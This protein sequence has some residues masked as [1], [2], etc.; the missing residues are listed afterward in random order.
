MSRYLRNLIIASVALH[1]VALVAAIIYFE[2]FYTPEEPPETGPETASSSSS[3]SSSSSANSNE[4]ASSSQSKPLSEDEIAQFIE[5]KKNEIKNS[6]AEEKF[7]KLEH[8]FKILNPE[9]KDS[10]DMQKLTQKGAKLLLGVDYDPD[11]YTAVSNGKKED[12]MRK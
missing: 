2:F 9:G 6:T 7:T 4:N 3:G 10:E 11:K 5:D 12:M 8:A 1:F